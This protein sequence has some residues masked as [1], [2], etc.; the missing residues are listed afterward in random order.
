MHVRRERI[1]SSLSILRFHNG[2]LTGPAVEPRDSGAVSQIRVEPIMPEP[3][4]RRDA[5]LL[6]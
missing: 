1:Q 6:H 3:L 4:P 2:D 5:Q